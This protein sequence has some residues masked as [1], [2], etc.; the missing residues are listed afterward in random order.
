MADHQVAKEF[1]ASGLRCPM[2]ILQTKKQMKTIEIGEILK[3]TAT[4]I[5]TKKDF[6]AFAKRTGNEI[7]ELV[8]EGDKLIWYLKRTK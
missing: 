6:P 3:V 7:V 4:D 8:E 2:P 1:D 5:G